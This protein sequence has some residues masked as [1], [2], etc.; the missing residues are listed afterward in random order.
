[1]NAS[2]P[3]LVVA[4]ALPAGLMIGILIHFLRW[5]LPT[6]LHEGWQ[7]QCAEGC[8]AGPAFTPWQALGAALSSRVVCGGCGLQT[9]VLNFSPLLCWLA[10]GGR[11]RRCGD[12]LIP[13]EVVWPE[14][15]II[16]ATAAVLLRF[17]LT[18]A[19]AGGLLFATSL[20]LLGLHLRDYAL[21]PNAISLP[22]LWAGL[23]LNVGATY[24]P[25][26]QAVLGAVA[27][28]LAPWAF[29]WAVK[30]ARG[31]EMIGYGAMKTLAAVGAWLGPAVAVEV[32]GSAF[33]LKA[34][35]WAW[36]ERTG[37]ADGVLCPLGPQLALCGV[38]ALVV[39]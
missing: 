16:V 5:L 29:Y 12:P 23:A 15:A 30:L 21:M 14:L 26:D 7:R 19:G 38:V 39:A 11:C 33:L 1:M 10:T 34:A 4:V 36:V 31:R 25:L 3:L 24:V 17:G 18:A 2:A 8:R 32:M 35:Q 37:D 9:R 27:G 13:F 20:I 6:R 28:Y 22:L